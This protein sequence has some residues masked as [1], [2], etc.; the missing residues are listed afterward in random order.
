MTE[1]TVKIEDEVI[2]NYGELFIK[3]FIEK[4]VEHL[5]LLRTMDNI[6]TQVNASGMDYEKELENVRQK[7]WE[8]YEK[9]FNN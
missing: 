3:N 6:E 4:Q 9:E 5:S 1:I 2:K 7:A 8:E